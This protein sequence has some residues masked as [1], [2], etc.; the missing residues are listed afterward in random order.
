MLY[1]GWERWIAT[2]GSDIKNEDGSKRTFQ[3]VMRTWGEDSSLNLKMGEEQDD[4]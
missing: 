4:E 3:T 2:T 1:N